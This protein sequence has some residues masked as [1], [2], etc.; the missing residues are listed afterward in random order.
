MVT[1][2]MLGL[3]YTFAEGGHIRIN[4][5]TSRFSGW[6]GRVLELLVALAALLM[7]AFFLYHAVLMV[8]DSF[9]YDMRADSISETPVYIPQ[10]MIVVG[11]TLLTL[12]VAAHALR[13]LLS[14]LRPLDTQPGA[15]RFPA[16]LPV[17]RALDR[18][19][20]CSQWA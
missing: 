18:L 9:S 4:I 2:V 7:C 3:G 11:F 5:L 20:R 13:R 8:Y 12:Q 6:P 10:T 17:G 15:V 1:V 16:D 14:I 19:S